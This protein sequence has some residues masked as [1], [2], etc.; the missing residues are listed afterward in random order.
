MK[1]YVSEELN[2]VLSEKEYKE[3]IERECKE[4][5]KTLK[6]ME[7]DIE[8][9]DKMTFC[10]LDNYMSAFANYEPLNN[11]SA[12]ELLDNESISYKITPSWWLNVEFEVIEAVESEDETEILESNIKITNIEIL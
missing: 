8:P 5:I 11:I 9:G 12:Y 4:Y 7:I 1:I 2:N 6:E 3:L 10:E